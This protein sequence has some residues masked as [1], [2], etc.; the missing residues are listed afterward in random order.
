MPQKISL[1]GIDQKTRRSD[2]PAAPKLQALCFSTAHPFQTTTYHS[3]ST[4]L[5][6]DDK[7]LELVTRIITRKMRILPTL[8][9]EIFMKGTIYWR[10]L[11]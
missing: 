9:C 6:V 3:L 10:V 11:E 5:I 8:S 1:A 7:Y 4:L 2:A